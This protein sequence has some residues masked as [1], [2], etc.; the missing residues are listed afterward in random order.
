MILN[1]EISIFIASSF[2][3]HQTCAENYKQKKGYGCSPSKRVLHKHANGI[4]LST[5]EKHT[6]GNALTD[7]N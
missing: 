5:I 6:E 1:V 3:M 4:T 7:T 2:K